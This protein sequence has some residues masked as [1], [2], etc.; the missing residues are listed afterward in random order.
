MI[1]EEEGMNRLS[2]WGAAGGTVL[3]FWALLLLLSCSTSK[4]PVVTLNRWTIVVPEDAIPAEKYAA[5]EFQTLWEQ[6]T[7][8]R[9]PIVHHAPE[10]AGN[11]FIGDSREMRESSAGFSTEGFAEEEL[12]IRLRPDNL[13]IAGGRPRGTLYGVYEFFEQYLGVRFLT[14]DHTYF[15]PDLADRKLPCRDLR[16]KPVFLFR[17][18]YMGE[19]RRNPKFATRLRVNT[20]TD[21]AKYGGK[22]AQ[23]LIN[24][25][26]FKLMP[27][28]E[29]GKDHPEYYALV[30][31]E[32][33][34]KMWGGGPQL[35]VSNPEVVDIVSRKILIQMEEHPEW[36]NYSVS[37]NDNDQYCRCDSCEAVRKREGTPMGPHLRFV[38]EVAR[39]IAKEHPDKF[40]GTLAYWYTR[41][42]PKN[43]RP[44]PNVQI[45]LAD[46]ENC[47]IHA[48]DDPFCP[49][50]RIFRKELEDWN[51][52]TREL[53]VWTYITDFRYYDLPFPNLQNIGTTIRFYARHGVKGVFAQGNSM[54]LSGEMSD[55]RN[56]VISRCLWNPELD[57]RELIKEFCQLHYGKAAPIV[58]EYLEFIYDWID[59]HGDH[60][61]CFANPRSLG[62]NR[63]FALR[64][65]AYFKRALAVAE[66]ET[67][68]LRVEKISIAAYRSMVE[69][70]REF[71]FEDG[72]LR[73]VYPPGYENVVQDYIRLA[74]KH[75]L[76]S[77]GERTSF[78][79]FANMLQEDVVPGIP[80]LK[81]E[82][83]I[84]K[85]IALPEKNG[86]V[87]VM[88]YKPAGRQL[89][90]MLQTNF[91]Y[92]AFDEVPAEMDDLNG[93]KFIF[94]GTSDDKQMV[95]RFDLPGGSRIERRIWLSDADPATIFCKTTVFHRGAE[96]RDYQFVVHPEFWTGTSTDDWTV[97]SAYVYRE[98]SWVRYNDSLRADKGP[99]THL[100]KE[101]VA[102]GR[103]AFFNHEA[104][105]G[106]LETYD[107][108]KF[109][110]IRTWW[111][112]GYSLLNL[113]L[114]TRRV[115]LRRGESF[116][117]TYQ[118]RYL[119]KWPP[120]EHTVARP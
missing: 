27:V 38:N 78:S 120:D 25:S 97:L 26:F 76:T 90:Q 61:T 59:R 71:V 80:A 55:L 94:Q 48:I 53:Y 2:K 37:Q 9:L 117:Y 35:D 74:A 112:P 54:N 12:Q 29:Y 101:A 43:I 91:D 107:P 58:L 60:P 108:A 72:R 89:L 44:E 24:H 114:L 32:R 115:T 105:F 8:V 65:L 4:V 110:R 103:H 116:S 100:L 21:S 96:P 86:K 79:E 62:L 69:A 70:G 1:A 33:K 82:N 87:V 3:T 84:W 5:E 73:S 106:I 88:E 67:V 19:I 66:D 64:A 23:Q 104:G 6:A 118:F 17:Y 99:K 20:V 49:K 47:R 102:G 56:Y 85:L 28:S 36:R 31:G 16:Y 10:P 46:I 93:I 39:R 119:K 81:I 40:I 57:S 75:G 109:E 18:T 68:R 15:P 13:A 113:E 22:T 77:T 92:G 63:D 50:N 111:I 7:G 95:M 98:G 11:I 34:L 51:R 42:P 83:D 45:Q 14:A 52:M 41:K 30:D